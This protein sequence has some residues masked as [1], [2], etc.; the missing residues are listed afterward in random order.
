MEARP[1]VFVGLV[2]GR[3]DRGIVMI[4][5]LLDG[6]TFV[7]QP[8]GQSCDGVSLVGDFNGWKPGI[9]PMKRNRNGTFEATVALG[10]GVYQFRYVSDGRCMNAEKPDGESPNGFGS[11]NCIVRIETAVAASADVPKGG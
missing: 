9:N 1:T 7:F 4:R 8:D 5:K 2:C 3:S 10:P 6:V 11:L